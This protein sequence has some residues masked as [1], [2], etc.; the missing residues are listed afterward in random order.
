MA[1]RPFTLNE[2]MIRATVK[3]VFGLRIQ[4]L[5]VRVLQGVP[6]QA[7]RLIPSGIRQKTQKNKKKIRYSRGRTLGRVCLCEQAGGRGG[8]RHGPSYRLWGGCSKIGWQD[9]FWRFLRPVVAAAA[10]KPKELGH[11]PESYQLIFEAVAALGARRVGSSAGAY[12][13][14]G[15]GFGGFGVISSDRASILQS[16]VGHFQRCGSARAYRSKSLHSWGGAFAQKSIAKRP[17][18]NNQLFGLFS[19]FGGGD[20]SKKSDL[21]GFIFDGCASWRGGR[22]KLGRLG[23][24]ASAFG[25]FVG[26]S[27]VSH[28][29]CAGRRR[30]KDGR[31]KGVTGTPVLGGS[32]VVL[33]FAVSEDN[34]VFSSG[35]KSYFCNCSQAPALAGGFFAQSIQ[36]RLEE[37]RLA[38]Q[39]YAARFQAQFYYS[40]F[41]GRRGFSNRPKNYTPKPEGHSRPVHTSKL[42]GFLPG[43]EFNQTKGA[44]QSPLRGQL[45][46]KN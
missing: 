45:D 13:G 35:R 6:A 15:R 16:G 18:K 22:P 19:A 29:A 39:P 43:G 1:K 30:H 41:S 11:R 17:A 25:G 9:R 34:R 40:C 28:G 12:C 2:R 38:G 32:F 46:H 27:P 3:K 37:G 36:A 44:S 21:L 33:A 5:K 31:T 14:H 10:E 23:Q 42:G 24:G 20:A 7:G 26:P 8:G 4:R